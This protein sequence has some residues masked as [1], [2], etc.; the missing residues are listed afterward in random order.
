MQSDPVNTTDILQ[1]L[2]TLTDGTVRNDT[3][4]LIFEGLKQFRATNPSYFMKMELLLFDGQ[5]RPQ[6]IDIRGINIL[7]L[8][9]LDQEY[10]L[11]VG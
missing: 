3:E 7:P 6:E 1:L 8:Y 2:K 5:Y 4:T 9:N 10:E 11:T